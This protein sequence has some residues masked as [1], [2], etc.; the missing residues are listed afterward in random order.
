MVLHK[1]MLD[2]Q[3][4]VLGAL[5]CGIRWSIRKDQRELFPAIATGRALSAGVLLQK[6]ADFAEQHIPCVM[7]ECV[8][9]AF[10]VVDV[11]HDDSNRS[12]VALR[13]VQLALQGRVQVTPVE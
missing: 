9:E 12:L 6:L 3:P 1:N 2:C 8:I 10:E 5:C 4:Q 7:A 11:E 13:P